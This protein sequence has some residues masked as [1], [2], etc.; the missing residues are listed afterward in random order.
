MF[1]ATL[2]HYDGLRAHVC[3]AIAVGMSSERNLMESH[4]SGYE[5][6]LLVTNDALSSFFLTGLPTA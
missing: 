4:I 5:W 6:N 1:L 2:R 3:R